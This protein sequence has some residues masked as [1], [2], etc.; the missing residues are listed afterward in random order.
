MNNENSRHFFCVNKDAK[1]KPLQFC[2]IEWNAARWVLVTGVTVFIKP[3]TL[4]RLF[5]RVL[6][7][8]KLSDILQL[9]G[10]P[11]PVEVSSHSDGFV[12]FLN[13]KMYAMLFARSS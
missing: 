7:S 1:Q 6:L 10:S 5:P 12:V 11:K 2:G 9:G 13:E 4:D 8:C 3:A